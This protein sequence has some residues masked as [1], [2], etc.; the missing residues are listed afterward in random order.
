MLWL[1]DGCLWLAVFDAGFD[2]L[3][4]FLVAIISVIVFLLSVTLILSHRRFVTADPLFTPKW[5]I[6]PSPSSPYSP[7]D[8]TQS[9][10]S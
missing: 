5:N 7:Q 4:I 3:I 6:P 2:L 8:P 10:H 9:S 1:I